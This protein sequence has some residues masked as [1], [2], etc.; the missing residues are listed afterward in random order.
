VRMT[1]NERCMISLPEHS[2]SKPCGLARS[3]STKLPASRQWITT[4]FAAAR[5]LRRRSDDEPEK[6][7]SAARCFFLFPAGSA[8]ESML[9]E[10]SKGS[11]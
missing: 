7:A 10:H 6:V 4:T 9:P 11:R 2:L 1:V 5:T 3:R 8:R